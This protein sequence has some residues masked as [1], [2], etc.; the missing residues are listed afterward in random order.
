M[1]AR[2]RIEQALSR[3]VLNAAPLPCLAPFATLGLMAASVAVADTGWINRYR[4]TIGFIADPILVAILIAQWIALSGTPRVY[5]TAMDCVFPEQPSL[6]TRLAWMPS[7][8]RHGV[9][10]TA[11][12]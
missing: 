5:A 4:D 3:S 1:P 11:A 2:G 10:I 6:E 8:W 9:H 7:G 12:R